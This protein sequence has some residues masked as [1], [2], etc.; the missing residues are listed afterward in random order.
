MTFEMCVWISILHIHDHHHR[1]E[2][3]KL[4]SVILECSKKKEISILDIQ[5]MREENRKKLIRANLCG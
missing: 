2:E 3:N 5:E 4:F 1:D